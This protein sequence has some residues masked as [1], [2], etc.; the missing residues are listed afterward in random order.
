MG[1]ELPFIISRSTLF[2]SGA[3]VQHWTGDN[4]SSW[5]DLYLSLSEIFNFGLFGIPFVGADICGFAGETTAE[6][7]ARWMQVGALYPFARNHN[8]INSRSQEPYAFSEPYVL[9]SSRKSLQLR[10]SLLKHYYSLF[11]DNNGAGTVFRPIFFEF[12]ND[13]KIYDV[14]WEFMIG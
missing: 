10:Y 1:H 14:D 11:L 4:L 3:Y 13:D 12:P 7:C 5:N 2:G 9:E 8:A 6:L